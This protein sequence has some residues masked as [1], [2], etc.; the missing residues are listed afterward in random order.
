MVKRGHHTGFTVKDLERTVTFYSEGLGLEIAS[1]IHGPKA[2][3]ADITGYPGCTL[4]VAFV[5]VPESPSIEFIQ[6]VAP[7]GEPLDMETYHPGSGHIALVVDNVEE[8]VPRLK[9]LGGT[10]RSQA[11][12]SIDSGPNKGSLVA[13][14][15]DPDGITVELIQPAG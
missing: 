8:L 12:I 5:A 9:S 14:V 2:Y 1:R 7:T 6:Y 13:Y 15:R 4:E 11:P 10:P 3:H